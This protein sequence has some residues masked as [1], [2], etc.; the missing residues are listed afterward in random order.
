MNAHKRMILH[1]AI[2]L[3][4]VLLIAG[5][6]SED[7]R[8]TQ[9]LRLQAETNQEMVRLNREVAQGISQLTKENAEFRKEALALQKELHTQRAEILVKQERLDA[10]RRQLLLHDPLV[11]KA[12]THVGIT[13]A[14]LLPVGLC[15]FLLQR[16]P[17]PSVEQDLIASD[18][19]LDD[20]TSARPVLIAP[21]T[22][23]PPR[24]LP[25]HSEAPSDSGNS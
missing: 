22:L 21:L 15:W 7:K 12:I 19:L 17:P 18:L 25:F 4:A 23:D 16:P 13:L 9:A 3:L 11:A 24:G 6:G 5:C 10:E 20:L 8:L 1:L 14:C 2:P